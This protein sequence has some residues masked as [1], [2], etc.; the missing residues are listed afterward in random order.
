MFV[1]GHYAVSS[2]SYLD[3]EF[4]NNLAVPKMIGILYSNILMNRLD[5]RTIAKVWFCVG[6]DDR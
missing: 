2:F 1:V 5:T 3:F 6:A 4:G